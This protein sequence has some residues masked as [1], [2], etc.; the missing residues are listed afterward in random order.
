MHFMESKGSLTCSCDLTTE[1]YPVC[2]RF[3]SVFFHFTRWSSIGLLSDS[4]IKVFFAFVI[5]PCL[6]CVLPISSHLSIDF[7]VLVIVS[8][9]CML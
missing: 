2:L 7:I 9:V 1:L 6:L 3:T 5:S 8:D 4:L